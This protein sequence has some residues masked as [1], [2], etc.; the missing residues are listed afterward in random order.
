MGFEPLPILIHTAVDVAFKLSRVALGTRM[1]TT[2]RKTSVFYVRALVLTYVNC[3]Y[4]VNLPE[5]YKPERM[6]LWR[7]GIIVV[8]LIGTLC[9]S[10]VASSSDLSLKQKIR[11]VGAQ[12]R[13]IFSYQPFF[14]VYLR[15]FLTY[16]FVNSVA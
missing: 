2:G 4:D 14:F 16:C 9:S 13:N 6:N 3:D 11:S 15:R 8:I 5:C 12:L 7:T 10:H 1:R